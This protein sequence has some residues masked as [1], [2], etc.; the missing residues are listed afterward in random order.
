[1]KGFFQGAPDIAVEVVSPSDRASE[2][3][4]KV[5]DW[6]QAGCSVVWV[7]D[8]EN[9]SVTVY[10]SRNEIAVLT[11]SDTLSG[12][13]VLPGFSVCRWRGSL[14]KHYGKLADRTS[15]RPV[16]LLRAGEVHKA[17]ELGRKSSGIP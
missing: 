14:R 9:R 17:R 11:A 1:M 7:V 10:R 16:R 5:Q 15:E 3:A 13:D 8:P 4:A 12:G 6:L 2:V